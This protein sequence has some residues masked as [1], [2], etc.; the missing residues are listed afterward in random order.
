MIPTNMSAIILNAIIF[1][2]VKRNGALHRAINSGHALMHAGGIWSSIRLVQEKGWP[3]NVVNS[4]GSAGRPGAVWI[5]PHLEWISDVVSENS[6]KM[7]GHRESISLCKTME[8][9][10]YVIGSNCIMV[11]LFNGSNLLIYFVFFKF[12]DHFVCTKRFTFHSN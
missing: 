11:S 10:S 7:S 3:R 1:R 8:Q 6:T 12:C 4:E 9:S 5:G 2:S